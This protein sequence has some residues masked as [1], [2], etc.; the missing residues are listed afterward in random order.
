MSAKPKT[1]RVPR[2]AKDKIDRL[3]NEL[4]ALE[5]Q[6]TK[7]MSDKDKDKPTTGWFISPED[8]KARRDKIIADNN[9]SVVAGLK[10]SIN[11]KK[12]TKPN[13]LPI[14]KEV[15]TGQVLAIDFINKKKAE[16]G[17]G[18]GSNGAVD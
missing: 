6:E 4:K 16:P 14:I 9:K 1:L 13:V 18:N 10:R 3:L 12:G 11:Q 8:Q 5:L 7:S 2:A 15:K 17:P